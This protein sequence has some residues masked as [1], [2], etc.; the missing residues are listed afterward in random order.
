MANWKTGLWHG[1]Q[2]C[3]KDDQNE[4][5]RSLG[6]SFL[7]TTSVPHMRWRAAGT[8]VVVMQA[9]G[10]DSSDPFTDKPIRPQEI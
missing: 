6:V 7:H 9:D 2:N 3:C 8:F 5:S 10:F 4:W 1:T